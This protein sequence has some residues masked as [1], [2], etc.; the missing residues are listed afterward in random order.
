MASRIR[1]A[2]L[3]ALAALLFVQPSLQQTFSKCNP[4]IQSCPADPALGQSVTVDFTKGA[5]DQFTASGNP[6]YESDGV[7]L[8]VAQSGDA[9]TLSS[10]W[11][12]MFG[13]V[14]VNKSVW[15]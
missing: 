12:I 5:S 7:H 15:K 1:A 10:K 13:R 11:Y 2:A 9:P 8:T 4:T 3:T 14:E 6:T